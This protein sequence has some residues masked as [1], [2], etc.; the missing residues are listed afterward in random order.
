MS[1]KIYLITMAIALLCSG[2]SCLIDYRIALGIL[3]SSGFSLLNMYLLSFGMKMMFKDSNAS[4]GVMMISS[5]GRFTLLLLVLYVAIKNPQLFN[6][7]GVVIGFTLFLV[8]LIID[9][10]SRRR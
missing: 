3:L 4:K 1:L 10:L 5:I 7:I 2:V 9:A 6:L 8:A